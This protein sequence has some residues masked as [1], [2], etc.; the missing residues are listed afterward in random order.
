MAVVLEESK[1]VQMLQLNR[2]ALVHRDAVQIHSYDLLPQYP[3]L[4]VGV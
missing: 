1:L 4:T 2:L 3:K